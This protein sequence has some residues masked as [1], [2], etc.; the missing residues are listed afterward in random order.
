MSAV[1]EV[2]ESG[3][4]DGDGTPAPRT[5]DA[6]FAEWFDRDYPRIVGVARQVLDAERH[7]AGVAAAR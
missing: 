2:H 3:P 6:R 1:V 4:G 7:H 5:G